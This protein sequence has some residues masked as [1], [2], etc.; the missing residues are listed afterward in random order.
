MPLAV[1]VGWIVGWCV[2]VVV[3]VIAASLLLAIIA[4]GRRIAR[5][6]ED[7]T[8]ALDGTREHTAPM[9]DIA[10]TNLAIDRVVRGLARVREDRSG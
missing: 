8:R 6:A 10:R 4:L 5:Q 2:G 3:V 1:D 9:F 7:I